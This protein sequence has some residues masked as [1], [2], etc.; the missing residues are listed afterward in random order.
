[1]IGPDVID[2][3]GREMMIDRFAEIVGAAAEDPAVG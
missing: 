1:V 3:T 2:L